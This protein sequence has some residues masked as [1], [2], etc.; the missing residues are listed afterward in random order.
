[1]PLIFLEI[2]A[3]DKLPNSRYCCGNFKLFGV[4]TGCRAYPS[5][6][7]VVCSALVPPANCARHRRSGRGCVGCCLRPAVLPRGG[8]TSHSTCVCGVVCIGKLVTGPCQRP[9]RNV[10]R[11][12]S[13]GVMLGALW[14][15]GVPACAGRTVLEFTVC[16][17][18]VWL[19]DWEVHL[20][21][22]AG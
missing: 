22:R 4:T 1:M 9:E 18:C 19:G 21:V 3:P 12:L 8:I 5:C 13:A 20:V 2:Y 15:R 11:H 6:R 17:G 10:C 16:L 14:R 7:S